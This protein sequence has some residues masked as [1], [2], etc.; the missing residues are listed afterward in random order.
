MPPDRDATIR[1]SLAGASSLMGGTFSSLDD[2]HGTSISVWNVALSFMRASKRM[3]V[4]I[5]KIADQIKKSSYWLRCPVW[6][7]I[8]LAGLKSPHGRP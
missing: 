5:Q 6:R 2:R 7:P 3:R 4:Q 1:V 8:P